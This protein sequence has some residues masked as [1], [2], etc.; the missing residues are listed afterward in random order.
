[1]LW[2]VVA[3]SSSTFIT[4]INLLEHIE[5]FKSSRNFVNINAI[6]LCT[7]IAKDDILSLANNDLSE[8]VLLFESTK[9]QGCGIVVYVK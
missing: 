4:H 8:E 6:N 9:W 7:V 1:M 3:F 2:P 5:L